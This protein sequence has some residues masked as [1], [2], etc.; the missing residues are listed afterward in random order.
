MVQID[1]E[2][3]NRL[4]NCNDPD[5]VQIVNPYVPGEL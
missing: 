2:K 5:E 4:Y 1:V 3:I